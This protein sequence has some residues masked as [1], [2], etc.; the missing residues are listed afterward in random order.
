MAGGQDKRATRGSVA[1]ENKSMEPPAS[2]EAFVRASLTSMSTK[3]DTILAGQ[4][5][6]EKRCE[7]LESRVDVNSSDIKDIQDSLNFDSAQIKDNTTELEQLKKRITDQGHELLR[8]SQCIATLETEMNNLQRY[9]RGFN[10]RILG[11]TEEENENCIES[12]ENILKDY[13]NVSGRV[14]ENAHRTGKRI[15]G[16]P[17]HII[18]RFYSLATRRSVMAVAREK[19]AE[20]GVR[21]IDDLTPRD[22]EAKKRVIPLMNKLYSDKQKPRFV[23]G[24]LY[25]NG[26]LVPQET[27]DAFLSQLPGK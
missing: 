18:A 26:K 15:G 9:T 1:A 14:I 7:T 19:L 20:T 3:M 13:F 24:Q 17:R 2:F 12:V 16:K 6:L 11:V 27:I 22:M 21:I 25:S 4:A 23:N 10:I 8:S 5:I